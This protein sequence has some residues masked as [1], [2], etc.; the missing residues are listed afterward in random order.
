MLDNVAAL[1]MYLFVLNDVVVAFLFYHIVDDQGYFR[2]LR[3]IYGNLWISGEIWHLQ[4]ICQCKSNTIT[5]GI[6][7][8][9]VIKDNLVQIFYHSNCHYNE[10]CRF[11]DFGIERVDFMSQNYHSFPKIT[12]W[13]VSTFTTY[14]S[15]SQ[16]LRH[17]P[18]NLSL[19][20]H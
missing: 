4:D 13:V 15:I 2:I 14:L 20:S 3:I 6:C 1:I 19:C 5:G 11:I 9:S 18:G 12:H 8:L 7:Y 16:K 10:S 17:R